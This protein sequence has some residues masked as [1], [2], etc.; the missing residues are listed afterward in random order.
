MRRAARIGF[1]LIRDPASST[2]FAGDHDG[3]RNNTA[4]IH[5]A[6][7]RDGR[8]CNCCHTTRS[9]DE[10]DLW[11]DSKAEMKAKDKGRGGK[12]HTGDSLAHVTNVEEY[13]TKNDK[14]TPKYKLMEHVAETS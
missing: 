14:M 7:Q 5:V 6:A 9:T 4:G 12:A 3:R 8:C 1:W 10:G 13:R 2:D 11:E